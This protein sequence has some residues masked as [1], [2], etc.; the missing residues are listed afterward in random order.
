MLEKSESGELLIY[1]DELL[2]GAVLLGDIVISLERAVAQAEELGHS[3]KREI[4]FL[5]VHSALHLLGYDHRTSA[6]EKEM[7]EKQDEILKILHISRETA[8]DE[9]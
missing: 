2:G 3:Q 9:G 7:F 5:T 4:A 8:D 6:E 1:E